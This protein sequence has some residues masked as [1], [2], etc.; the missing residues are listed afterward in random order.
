MRTEISRLHH[1]LQ[2]TMIYVTHDQIEAMA[3]GDKIAIMNFGV[4]QQM[5]TPEEVFEHPANEFVA[6]FIGEPPMNF[7]DCE[8][9]RE[10]GELS[11]L[12][13]SFKVGSSAG[14]RDVL[15]QKGIPSRMRLGM[16]PMDI[17]VS[18]EKLEPHYTAATVYTIEPQGDGLVLTLQVGQDLLRAESGE[19]LRVASGDMLWWNPKMEKVHLFDKSSG[20]NLV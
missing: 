20:V 17:K 9:V 2:T 10:N 3:L 15:M 6:G 18:L 12:T 1:Q 8:V 14:L 19:K 11:F 16:R 4:L 13:R 5:G 7:F